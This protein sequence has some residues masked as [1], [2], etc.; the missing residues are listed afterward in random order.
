MDPGTSIGRGLGACML[1]VPQAA[2]AFCN[3]NR[4]FRLTFHGF[5][6]LSV[7]LLRG[8]PD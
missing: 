6:L 1:V 4:H 5:V 3:T 8:N 2:M 7:G